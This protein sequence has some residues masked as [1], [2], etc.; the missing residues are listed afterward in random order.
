[1]QICR[2]LLRFARLDC[3]QSLFEYGA[4]LLRI[5]QTYAE[6]Y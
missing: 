6:S 3:A 1:M 2:A 5:F 4:E